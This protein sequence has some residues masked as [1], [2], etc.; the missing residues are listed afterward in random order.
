MT[1]LGGIDDTG[2][3]DCPDPQPLGTQARWWVLEIHEL[4]HGP[5]APRLV[6]CAGEYPDGR[7]PAAW[8]AAW[9]RAVAQAATLKAQQCEAEAGTR[10]T[11]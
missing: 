3:G 5:D 7:V 1:T 2:Y 9:W 10:S 6:T 11:K 8:R 4:D